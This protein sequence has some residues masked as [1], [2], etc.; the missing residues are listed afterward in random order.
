LDWFLF[1]RFA[2]S[3]FGTFNEVWPRERKVCFT[4]YLSG[5][6]IYAAHH[7]ASKSVQNANESTF[8]VLKN[9]HQDDFSV[10]KLIRASTTNETAFDENLC[11][12]LAQ[13][14]LRRSLWSKKL[15]II[16]HSFQYR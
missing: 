2:H 12:N 14:E 3:G 5:V 7:N 16:I 4:K 9:I 10:S 6:L 1:A 8:A 13:N 11:E 15:L